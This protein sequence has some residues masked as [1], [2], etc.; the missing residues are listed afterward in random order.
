MSRFPRS[1][2]VAALMS[3]L[4]AAC[5]STLPGTQSGFSD[6][7]TTTTSSTPVTTAPTTTS[8]T[9]VTTTSTTV[10]A[11]TGAANPLGQAPAA[12]LGKGD[13]GAQ[14]LALEQRLAALRFDV[15]QPND[16]YEDNTGHAVM[17]FQ[18]LHGLPRTGRAGQDVLDKLVAAGPPPPLVPGGGASRVEIDLP[19]QVLFLYKADTLFVV[20][21]VSTANGKRF[22]DEGRCRTAVTPPGS[23]K[24]SWRHPGWRKSDLGRLFN[25]VYF[26][27]GIAIHGYPQVPGQPASH[28]C[29]RIPMSAAGWFFDQ[30]PN[31]T[32]VYVF[33]GKTPP[34]PKP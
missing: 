31:G 6:E 27:E 19:R 8:T 34:T 10:A 4:L 5:E 2:A 14:V 11:A 23:F 3:V 25:P 17:A 26:N 29:V 9:A 12:G 20:L 33:D 22:C 21:P 15:G 30:V 13:R 7:D 24:V 1:W 16:L 18:K 28:G 32:P